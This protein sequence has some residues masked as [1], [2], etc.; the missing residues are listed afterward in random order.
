MRNPSGDS[1]NLVYVVPQ[2]D[3]NRFVLVFFH[4]D[5]TNTY[6]FWMRANE[7]L[8]VWQCIE[9][10][11]EMTFA[12]AVEHVNTHFITAARNDAMTRYNIPIE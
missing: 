2:D 1:R 6:T 8:G 4:N 9:W 3:V 10:E 11:G 12:E 7:T 5:N